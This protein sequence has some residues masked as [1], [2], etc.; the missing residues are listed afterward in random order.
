M[1]SE[2]KQPENSERLKNTTWALDETVGMFLNLE[3]YFVAQELCQYKNN[4]GVIP[5]AI[6]Y[7]RETQKRY[8]ILYRYGVQLPMARPLD[9]RRQ[10]IEDKL[11]RSFLLLYMPIRKTNLDRTKAYRVEQ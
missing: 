8:L 7:F 1:D 6:A 5:P 2:L 4:V 3:L 10:K 9:K 11:D